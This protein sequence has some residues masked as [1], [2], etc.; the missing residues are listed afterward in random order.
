MDTLVQRTDTV[1]RWNEFT[2]VDDNVVMAN[3]QQIIMSGQNETDGE[4]GNH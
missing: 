1:G 4:K 3:L 2:N